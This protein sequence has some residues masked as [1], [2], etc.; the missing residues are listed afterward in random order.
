M[1][2]TQNSLRTAISVALVVILVAT[3]GMALAQKNTRGP[4]AG[5]AGLLNGG[6]PGNRLEM[7]ARRLDLSDDQKAAIEK[8]HAGNEKD[9][10]ALRKD[11]MKLRHELQGEMM[12]DNPSEKTILDLNEKIGGLKTELKAV[13]L[14]TRLAIRKQLTAEQRDQMLLMGGPGRAGGHGGCG[15]PGGP[16]AF[17]GPGGRGRPDGRF[18]R[19]PLGPGAGMGMRNP[20]CPLLDKN[21][22]NEENAQ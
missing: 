6:G 4:R 20:D 1:K 12:Q 18:G 3:A 19:A 7:L 5:H 11:I 22:V 2:K 14:K 16:G 21:D 8:I 17:D 10:I 15:R 9:V 13:H